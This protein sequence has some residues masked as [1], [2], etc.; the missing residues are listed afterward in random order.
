MKRKPLL[1]LGWALMLLT[2]L[3]GCGST[4]RKEEYPVTWPSRMTSSS[5]AGC[6]DIS[7]TYKTSKGLPLLPFFVFG[8]TDEA[9][10]DWRNLIQLY[11]ERL[12]IDPDDTTVTINSPDSEHIEVLVAINGITIKRQTLTR[13]YQSEF[14]AV[15]FGQH[16]RSFRC[17]PDSVVI[18]SSYIHDW[19]VYN[20]PD[21][22]K[23]HRYRKMF[24]AVGPLG[25][26]E[27][28]FYF[29][30]T[31]NGSLVA[32]V[33]LYGCYPCESLDEFWR[34]WPTILSP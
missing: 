14:A 21:E 28:Y 32:R 11:K 12:L 31:I 3:P 26:S 24:G 17:E 30:K 10:L 2:S 6:P 19:D 22:E 29:S 1:F 5:S 9:S 25:V 16:K 34:R 27:G 33:H 20:L 7:G 4:L 18:N 13:S 15:M 23:K 8:I